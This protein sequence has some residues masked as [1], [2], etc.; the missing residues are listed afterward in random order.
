M[1]IR[2]IVLYHRDGERSHEVAFE[3]GALNIVTGVSDTGKSVLIEIVDYCLG[4]D[5][6]GVYRGPELET[7][8]WYGLRLLVG[9]QPV[10]I[11]RRAPDLGRKVSENAT[12]IAGI[13]EAP[14]PGTLRATTNAKELTT[15][16]A[17]LIGIRDAGTEAPEDGGRAR[18]T[19]TLR[20]SLAY[21]FQRQRLIA[22]PEY[23]FAG[24][25][26]PFAA[27]AIRDTL[28]YFLGVVDR[29]ALQQRRELRAARQDVT[30]L[31][32]SLAVAT[33]EANSLAR[34]I[35]MLLQEAHDVGLV[36]SVSSED[37]K[38]GHAALAAAVGEAQDTASGELAVEIER[39]ASLQDSRRDLAEQLRDVR[40]ARRRLTERARIVAEYSSEAV[41]QRARLL[42][43]ELLPKASEEQEPACP[44]CGEMPA[45][46]DPT[47]DQVREALTKAQ[48]QAKVSIVAEPRLQAEIDAFDQRAAALRGKVDETNREL[49]AITA[50]SEL[51]RRARSRAEVQAYVRGRIAAFLEQH[52]STDSVDVAKLQRDVGHAE[53]RVKSLEDQLGADA[54]RRRTEKVLADVGSHMT[55]MAQRLQLGFSERGVRLDPAALTVVADAPDRPALLNED[56]G[57]GKNWVGYHLVTLLALHRYFIDNGRPVPRLLMLDQPTQAFFPSELRNAGNRSLEQLPDE[58]Q[59]FVRQIFTLIRDEVAAL[60]GGLQVIV[61]D[62]AEIAAPWFNQAA[63]HNWRDGR[64]LVPRDWVT[65][66]GQAV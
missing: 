52:P 12:V 15:H 57:S 59:A 45:Q 56:I 20:H 44:L 48:A 2:A 34:R 33:D 49:A 5:R 11:A 38:A 61:M 21:V 1:Q 41:E 46:A 37:L 18:V 55:E 4:S 53:A 13:D 60:G 43:L 62:H 30:Q 42:S 14:A 29:D 47:V 7:V 31:R 32:R 58:D 10:F 6:H 66:A 40:A 19:A 9:G 35:A 23:L 26:H 16:L 3:P 54:T 51:A 24:Q 8:G 25:D 17:S 63:R 28:P 50:R 64:A 36:P 65:D 22:D 27:V 39:L